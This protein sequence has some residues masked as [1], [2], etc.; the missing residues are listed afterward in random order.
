MKKI[1]KL[2]LVMMFLLS[3]VGCGGTT[4]KELDY[5][6]IQSDI[7]LIVNEE[8]NPIFGAMEYSSEPSDIE[9]LSSDL[10]EDMLF[11]RPLMNISSSMYL[12]VKPV[13]GQEADVKLA[14]EDYL[15]A[16]A[17]NWSTYLPDQYDLVMNHLLTEVEGQIVLVI[18]SD[19]DAVLE[20][21]KNSVV[22]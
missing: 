2:V 1:L 16:Y 11:A 14:I 3:L 5:Q 22:D 12:I 13:A 4:V 21:I 9:G 15:E 18:S 7:S 19:N 8:G 10:V 17:E 20:V 6:K